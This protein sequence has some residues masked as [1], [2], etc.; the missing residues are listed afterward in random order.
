MTNTRLF[1]V[2]GGF[3]KSN[4]VHVPQKRPVPLEHLCLLSKPVAAG[5]AGVRQVQVRLVISH[6]LGRL[7]EAGKRGKTP[8]AR[9]EP[10][11]CFD[12]G[13]AQAKT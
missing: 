3:W 12:E 6:M 1:V 13:M 4:N 7:R 10:N 5:G 11:K 2:A 8:R 9:A